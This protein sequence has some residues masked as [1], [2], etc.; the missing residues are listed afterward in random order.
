[1]RSASGWNLANRFATVPPFFAAVTKVGVVLTAGVC[2]IDDHG[3]FCMPTPQAI[4][5]VSPQVECT[6]RTA[7]PSIACTGLGQ[8]LGRLYESVPIGIGVIKLSYVVMTL[9]VFPPLLAFTLYF[10]L[11]VFGSKYVLTNKSVQEWKSIGQQ[12]V[13]QVA[14]GD[15]AEVA[16]EQTPGQAFFKASDLALLAADDS[17]LLRLEGITRAEVFRQTI[18]QARDARRQTEASLSAIQAR[19]PA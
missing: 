16:L 12:L 17:V 15:V 10:W 2:T 11:K 6:L 13:G 3:S 5:G 19:Q 1:M 7:Y 8:L 9:L 4:A 18:L 14:L